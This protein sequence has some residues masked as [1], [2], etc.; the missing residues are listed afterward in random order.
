MPV[1]VL[2]IG[3]GEYTTGYVGHAAGAASDKPAGVIAISMIDLRRRGLVGDLS[4]VDAVGTRMPIV[5]E[6]MQKKIGNAYKEMNCDIKTF[7]ADDVEFDTKAYQTAIKELPKGSMCTIFTPDNTHFEIA[8]FAIENGIHVLLAKPAVKTLADL[9]KL[10]EKAAK[11]GV[12]C[13]VEYHKR[14]DP[15]YADAKDRIRGMG[16]FSYYNATMTQGKQQLDTFAGWAGKSSDISYYLNSHHIDFHCWSAA[17]TAKP[18]RVVAMGATGVAEKKLGRAPIEDTITIMTQWKNYED[19]SLGTAVYTASWIAP[20]A[21]CHTQQYFHYMGQEGE[22]R[23]DQAHRGYN[24]SHDATGYATLNPLYMK[25]T[26]DAQGYFAGQQGYGYRSLEE[27]VSAV[28][29]INSGER[30]ASD[31]D[32]SQVAPVG[33]KAVMFGT[34]ILEAGRRSLDNAGAPVFIEYN[35][36]TGIPTA[37]NLSSAN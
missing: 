7:P 16:G 11:A 18:V 17:H 31:Y 26:P 3:A 29:K 28:T 34:A 19:G 36:E 23:A 8:E 32:Q 12:L 20:K 25:Y 2:M 22:V 9:H 13:G 27:F 6:L 35:E 30:K 24:N 5:R 4:M 15:I 14:F 1:N 37:L 33:T 21:D 10:A